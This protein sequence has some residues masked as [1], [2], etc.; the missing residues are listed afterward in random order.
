[1][2]RPFRDE[3][4]LISPP[5]YICLTFG[6]IRLCICYKFNN[7]CGESKRDKMPSVHVC[8]VLSHRDIALPTGV[9]PTRAYHN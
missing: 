1:M 2:D 9:T 3:D 5:V 4:L 7:Y 6:K 8:C